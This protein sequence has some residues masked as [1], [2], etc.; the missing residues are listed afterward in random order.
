MCKLFNSRTLVGVCGSA[1][2][3]ISEKMPVP[4]LFPEL[5][6]VKARQPRSSDYQMVIMVTRT[7]KPYIV[8]Y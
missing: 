1:Q 3:D 6:F 8:K 7:T 5:D 4:E 2:R